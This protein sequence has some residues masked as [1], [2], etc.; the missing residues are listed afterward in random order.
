MIAKNI[1]TY[2]DFTMNDIRT[3]VG[4]HEP[5]SIDLMG[6]IKLLFASPTIGYGKDIDTMPLDELTELTMT[7]CETG[8][9]AQ[10]YIRRTT[11]LSAIA[12]SNENIENDIRTAL[13]GL[14]SENDLDHRLGVTLSIYMG[15]NGERRASFY[16][17][18]VPDEQGRC[19]GMTLTEIV[20]MKGQMV[21]TNLT[22]NK[23]LAGID[24]ETSS[25]FM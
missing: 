18:P 16:L 17:T 14:L 8:D 20:K 6:R 10:L 12:N 3:E 13:M 15:Q 25:L 2:Y 1:N 7:E 9:L 23:P 24:A 21:K 19:P 11:R 4:G 22:R 5:E